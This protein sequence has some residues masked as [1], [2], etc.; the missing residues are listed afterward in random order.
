MSLPAFFSN[1]ECSID[2][3]VEVQVLGK[4]GQTR[5]SSTSSHGFV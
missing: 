2:V 4:L 3:V 1:D 5:A